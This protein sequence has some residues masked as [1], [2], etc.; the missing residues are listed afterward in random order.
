MKKLISLILFKLQYHLR[1]GAPQ[2]VK[3]NQ[4]L[5]LAAE[6]TRGVPPNTVKA[7]L[8]RSINHSPRQPPG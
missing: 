5:D 1:P 7:A 6:N 8:R 4:T 3:E 2:K